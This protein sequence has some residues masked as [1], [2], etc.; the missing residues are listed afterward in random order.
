MEYRFL[1]LLL[2]IFLFSCKKENAKVDYEILFTFSSGEQIKET[3][4][5]YEKPKN[6]SL[7][8]NYE[9][10]TKYLM[11][12]LKN[13]LYF[14]NKETRLDLIKTDEQKIVG[15]NSIK[16]YFPKASFANQ[17]AADCEGGIN[18]EGDYNQKSRK[19]SV[20]NGTFEYYW[21]NTEVYGKNDTILTGA[22][23]LKRLKRELW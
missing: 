5:I 8:D 21:H 1:I 11:K 16:L 4:R 13:I 18:M 6:Y 23:T 2:T 3:G 15:S 19:Y 22:W 20:E 9:L 10:P 17:Q 12:R 14:R 7:S